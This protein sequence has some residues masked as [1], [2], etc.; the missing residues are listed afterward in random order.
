M[1]KASHTLEARLAGV[2]VAV[3]LLAAVLMLTGL[4][5]YLPVYGG[6]PEGDHVFTGE[7]S[8]LTNPV[9][10]V[11][12]AMTPGK[13]GERRALIQVGVMVLL[14]TPV[15]RVIFAGAGFVAGR[16]RFYAG[17]SLLVLAVLV[18]SFFW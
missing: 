10:M 5:M 12:R 14:M 1:E 4:A 9:D 18:F 17:L 15:I 8:Y 2:T 3:V 7:P 11:V 16:D 6:R 13:V